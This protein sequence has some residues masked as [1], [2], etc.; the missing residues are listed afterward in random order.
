MWLVRAA[1]MGKRGDQVQAALERLEARRELKAKRRLEGLR[2]RA[3]ARWLRAHKRDPA[4]ASRLEEARRL[5]R[6]LRAEALLAAE[7]AD[8]ADLLPRAVHG[9][10]GNIRL[11][12]YLYLVDLEVDTSVAERALQGLLDLGLEGHGFGFERLA[13]YCD[14]KDPRVEVVR[15]VAE[16]AVSRPP[17]S[18]VGDERLPV[19]ELFV[20]EAADADALRRRLLAHGAA[21]GDPRSAA[22]LGHRA[23][24]SKGKWLPALRRRSSELAVEWS[25]RRLEPEPDVLARAHSTLAGAAREEAR[26]HQGLGSRDEAGPDE[27]V[28]SLAAR[29]AYEAAREHFADSFEWEAGAIED[30][31]R[32]GATEVELALSADA[33]RA[34]LAE[35][36]SGDLARG[37]F[38]LWRAVVHLGRLDQL[39]EPEPHSNLDKSR[40]KWRKRL[41]SLALR[42]AQ[43]RGP[44]TREGVRW[45]FLAVLL[46]DPEAEKALRDPKALTHL[47]ALGAPLEP[48]APLKGPA[49]VWARMEALGL[50]VADPEGGRAR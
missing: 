22:E 28:L 29:R 18:F 34:W 20:G 33:L 48:V 40:E 36:Q 31:S 16:R 11:W 10:S 19:D 2:E 44:T 6:G 7:E 45:L 32:S 46:G 17:T 1:L 8:P 23:R 3:E 21:R 14:E 24:D 39:L 5:G 13:H 26:A 38:A 12:A 42:W 35:G 43:A 9:L 30:W 37:E 4:Q 49:D 15:R 50:E 25:H 47:G 41:R 27:E